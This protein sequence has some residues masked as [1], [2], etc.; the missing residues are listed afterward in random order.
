MNNLVTVFLLGLSVDGLVICPLFAFGLTMTDKLEGL[1]FLCGRMIGL[2][3]FSIVICFVGRLVHIPSSYI[4]LAFG[5]MIITLGIIR[6]V[7]NR[8]NSLYSMRP[9]KQDGAFGCRKSAI[10][11]GRSVGFLF[12]LFRGFANPGRKFVYLA[13]LIVGVDWVQSVATAFVFGISSSVYL[14]L[15]FFA[16]GLI[17]KLSPHKRQIGLIGGVVMIGIGIVFGWLAII[18]LLPNAT[19]QLSQV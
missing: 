15:G 1:R 5:V 19:P 17:E 7:Q 3:L 11:N 9:R 4:N 8:K 2:I 6:V 12:G 18:S 13:P 16:A 14:L 10:N